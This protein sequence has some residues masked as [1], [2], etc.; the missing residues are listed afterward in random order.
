MFPTQQTLAEARRSG[1]RISLSPAYVAAAGGPRF[2][3]LAPPLVDL[4][5]PTMNPLVQLNL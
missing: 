2:G 3:I 4:F 5:A 1:L